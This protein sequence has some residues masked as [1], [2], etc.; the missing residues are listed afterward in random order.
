MNCILCDSFG[1]DCTTIR[2]YETFMFRKP[3]E[4]RKYLLSETYSKE[5]SNGVKFRKLARR[6]TRGRLVIHQSLAFLPGSQSL[7]CPS[8]KKRVRQ[9]SNV[10][11]LILWNINLYAMTSDKCKRKNSLVVL[12]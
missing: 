11:H 8:R 3:C 5:N 6:F 9:L 10:T 7:D 1:S 4:L 2:L 12:E